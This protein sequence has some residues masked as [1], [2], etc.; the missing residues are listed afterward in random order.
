MKDLTKIYYLD[1]T[2]ESKRNIPFDSNQ[3][4]LHINGVG[5]SVTQVFGWYDLQLKKWYRRDKITEVNPLG[6]SHKVDWTPEP[7]LQVKD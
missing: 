6:W 7:N 4:V 2:P 5:K 1:R 3:R